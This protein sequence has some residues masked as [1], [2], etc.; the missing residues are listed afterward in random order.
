[1]WNAVKA[2]KA[3]VKEA[4][5]SISGMEVDDDM[6]EFYE[7][8]YKAFKWGSPEEKARLIEAVMDLKLIQLTNYLEKK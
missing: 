6:D 1:M 4:I 3:E 7:I 2:K 8:L 5:K